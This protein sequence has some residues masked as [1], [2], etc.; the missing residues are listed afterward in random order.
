L[1]AQRSF[2]YFAIEYFDFAELR[3]FINGKKRPDEIGVVC[4]EWSDMIR[5]I[6][7]PPSREECN[8]LENKDLVWH[9][10]LMFRRF[11]TGK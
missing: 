8:G 11:N 10:N 2:L 3:W 9:G 1:L 7:A 6:Y 5:I 4:N